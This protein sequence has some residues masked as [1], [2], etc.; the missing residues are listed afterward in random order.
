MANRLTK[1]ALV[2]YIP[3]SPGTPGSPYIPATPSYTYTSYECPYIS[4]PDFNGYY[5]VTLIESGSV[6]LLYT[7]DPSAYCDPTVVTVAGTAAV[8]AVAPTPPT[9]AQ[10]IIDNNLGWNSSAISQVYVASDGGFRWKISVGSVGVIAGFAPYNADSQISRVT[11]GFYYSV[12]GGMKI[13]ESGVVK[14]TGLSYTSGQYVEVRRV[15]TTVTYYIN[16]ALVYTS[17]VASSGNAYLDVQLYA[18]GDYVYDPALYGYKL[19]TATGSAVA[20]GGLSKQLRTTS[21]ATASSYASIRK[22]GIVDLAATANAVASVTAPTLKLTGQLAATANAVASVTTAYFPT[23]EAMVEF[24]PLQGYSGEAGIGAAAVTTLE[25]LTGLASSDAI[26]IFTTGAN[27]V[28]YPLGGTAHMLTGGLGSSSS[29]MEVLAGLSADHAYGESSGTMEAMTGSGFALA[30]DVALL[31]SPTGL[32]DSLSFDI[33]IAVIMSETFDAAS[34]FTVATYV[35]TAMS[36]SAAVAP[37]MTLSGVYTANMEQAL[38]VLADQGVLDETA[39]VWVM[40][41]TNSAPFRYE[42]Y[43]FTRYMQIGQFTYG[44]KSDGV[45]LLGQDDTD[46]GSP[47][48]ASIDFGSLDFG[49]TLHKS[50]TAAY[51]GVKGGV[52][53]LR[54]TDDT[55]QTYT[56]SSIESANMNVRRINPGRGLRANYYSLQLLN[57]EGAD[58]ELADVEF[59]A[60]PLKRRV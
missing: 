24:Q 59:R 43:D 13:I 38:A 12:S 23:S 54:V 3:G 56:Y 7:T 41:R 35:D 42:N 30:E 45:Y 18:A 14:A 50:L 46:A 1:E 48:R 33:A 37:S 2:T 4:G 15:G 53:Y 11:H 34:V 40:N 17:A 6:T 10:T 51:L 32:S 29:E 31:I 16:G 44:V 5:T 52:L 20:T 21:N 55:G 8:P 25:A 49:T 26:I 9:A 27:G 19:L 28:L 57:A 39:S 58:F 47:I 22:N 36:S 60:I